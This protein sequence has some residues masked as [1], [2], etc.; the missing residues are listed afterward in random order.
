MFIHGFILVRRLGSTYRTSK[1]QFHILSLIQAVTLQV[2]I[3]YDK[4]CNLLY[5][6]IKIC[7]GKI[8]GTKKVVKPT[9]RWLD[10]EG[11][12]SQELNVKR[13]SQ[14]AN[15]REGWASLAKEAKVQGPQNQGVSK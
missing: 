6:C 1:N 11:N 3:S 8:E 9:M 14:K 12:D 15:K 13:W 5:F 4:N 7:E 10:D 2:K